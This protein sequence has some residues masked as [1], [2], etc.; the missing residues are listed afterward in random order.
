MI[1]RRQLDGRATIW[2]AAR[3]LHLCHLSSSGRL[4]SQA[5]W[6]AWAFVLYTTDFDDLHWARKRNTGNTIAA[7]IDGPLG[8]VHM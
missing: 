8:G 5:H 4:G 1:I 6:T 7:R 3:V 2:Q